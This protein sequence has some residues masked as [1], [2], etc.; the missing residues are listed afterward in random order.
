MNAGI[1]RRATANPK[2]RENIQLQ[3]IWRREGD[4]NPRYGLIRITV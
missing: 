2:R 3:K 1:L 4:S